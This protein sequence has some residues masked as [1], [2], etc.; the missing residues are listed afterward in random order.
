MT[1]LR[2]LTED[3]GGSCDWGYCD[4]ESVAERFASDLGKWLPVCAKHV[5]P[6]PARLSPGRASCPHC[7][8][9]YALSVQGLIR[10]HSHRFARCPG[11]GTR[12]E[13]T[14]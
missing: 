13:E 4:T 10:A 1:Q 6:A 9:S 7:G 8:T 2:E 3:S 12:P 14:P 5:G 11:S